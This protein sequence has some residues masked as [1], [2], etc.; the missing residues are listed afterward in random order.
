MMSV[1]ASYEFGFGVTVYQVPADTMKERGLDVKQ[2]QAGMY[3]RRLERV[4][5]F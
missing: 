5:M 4:V 1:D 2:V 3:D